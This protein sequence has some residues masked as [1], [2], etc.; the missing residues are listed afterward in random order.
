[1]SSQITEEEGE[2]RAAPT[3]IIGGR[4][5]FFP[6][7]VGRSNGDF[8]KSFAPNCVFS[9]CVLKILSNVL[10]LQKAKKLN[11]IFCNNPPSHLLLLWQKIWLPGR[12]SA[13]NNTGTQSAYVLS[14]TDNQCILKTYTCRWCERDQKEFDF[15]WVG[16]R[17]SVIDGARFRTRTFTFFSRSDTKGIPVR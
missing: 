5:F 9:L 14:T 13:R 12:R 16:G 3:F 8:H 7:V 11:C 6:S 1:M 17:G 10:S 4:F 15:E 2:E